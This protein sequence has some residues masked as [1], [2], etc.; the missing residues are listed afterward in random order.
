MA[1]IREIAEQL[2]VSVATVSR[3]LNAYP[4]VAPDTRER[5]L[6]GIAELDFVPSRAARSLVTGRT[7]VI[8]IVL[9]T[10]KG[11]PGIEHPFFQE[12]LAGMRESV[13]ERGFDLLLFSVAGSGNGSGETR[14]LARARQH[15]VDGVVL[16]GVD[17]HDREIDELVGSGIPIMAVDIDLKGGRTGHVTSDNVAGASMAVRHLSDLGHRRIGLIGGSTDTRPGV[18]RLL[19]YRRALERIGLPYRPEFA[20]EGDFYARSGHTEMLELLRLDEAPTAV[21]AAADLMAAGAIQALTEHG[22]R[23][24]DD[25]SVVGFDDVHLAGLL[26]PP[27]TT[28]RQHKRGLGVAAGGAL[29]RM[30]EEPDLPPEDVVLPVELV[31]RGST[32][33]CRET[34][35]GRE[36][37]PTPS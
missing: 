1:T 36:G 15:R 13:G 19:G 5:V 32:G 9:A 2:G 35:P 7:H 33:P 25:V 11:R 22:L 34:D 29:V 21:F 27:L 26:Q 30:I 28:I 23:C 10:G 3:V 12:V 4:D 24:P 31:I 20:R 37:E 18:D 17:A 6:A 14:Y 16:M 8:G